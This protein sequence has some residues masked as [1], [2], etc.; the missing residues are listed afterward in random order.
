M[1]CVHCQYLVQNER[2]FKDVEMTDLG[3]IRQR[4]K[5]SKIRYCTVSAEGEPLLNSHL[6]EILRVLHDEHVETIFVTNGLLLDSFLD[7]LHQMVAKVVVSLDAP[8]AAVYQGIRNAPPEIFEKVCENIRLF[9]EKRRT[10][11]MGKGTRL[12]IKFDLHKGLLSSVDAMIA[13][14]RDLSAD[15]IL[16]GTINDEKKGGFDLLMKGDQEVESQ[17]S[18]LRQKYSDQNIVWPKLIDMEIKGF[19]SML[20]SG[21][22]VNS[23][24]ALS[25][26]CHI[27]GN[28]D[29]YGVGDKPT[30]AMRAFKKRF[31]SSKDVSE[32][33][34]H[35]QHCQRRIVDGGR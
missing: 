25:P 6:K 18:F 30:V 12:G 28:S 2:H 9:A 1:R 23:D 32:M 26:C 31:L 19:C 22:V 4:I 13:R 8:N 24:F 16:F 20:F 33:D 21:K 35:C 17:L 29:V 34:Y 14:A 5:N 15:E 10:I 27:A 7:V 3:A 11:G